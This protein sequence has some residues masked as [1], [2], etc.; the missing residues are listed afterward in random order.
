MTRAIRILFL[1]V[2]STLL[3]LWVGNL[4]MGIP[5]EM[6][7]DPK[8]EGLSGEDPVFQEAVLQAR[9]A[10][11]VVGVPLLLLLVLTIKSYRQRNDWLFF[12]VLLIGLSLFQVVPVLAIYQGHT[13]E[14][15]LLYQGIVSVFW[16]LAAGQLLACYQLYQLAKQERSRKALPY[17]QGRS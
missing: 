9:F 7:D 15:L 10:S 5:A 2:L 14:P 17:K 3:L 11:L 4:A 8:M 13:T 1:A 16:V 6:S 12:W